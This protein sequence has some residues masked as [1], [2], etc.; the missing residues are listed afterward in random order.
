[1]LRVTEIGRMIASTEAGSRYTAVNGLDV[2][3][4]DSAKL[5]LDKRADRGQRRTDVA[6]TRNLEDRPTVRHRI[7]Y[8]V[9]AQVCRRDLGNLVGAGYLHA[10][11]IDIDLQGLGR[12][13]TFR[14]SV[15]DFDPGIVLRAREHRQERAR[16]DR[17]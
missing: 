17:G 4:P 9:H 2:I 13:P 16:P 15:A 7:A 14:R 8:H 5:L 10:V 1:M 3:I 12:N 6:D 11:E